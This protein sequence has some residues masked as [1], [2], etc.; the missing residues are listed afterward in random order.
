MQQACSVG[1]VLRVVM[2]HACSTGRRFSMIC[3]YCAIGAE[4]NN[5]FERI[6]LTDK[7]KTLDVRYLIN[8]N[9]AST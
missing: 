6:G 4:T 7:P 2:Q 3:S 8:I 5:G 9:L 1:R